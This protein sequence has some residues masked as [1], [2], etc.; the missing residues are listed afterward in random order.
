M[1]RRARHGATR[2]AFV[3]IDK[4]SRGLAISGK[5]GADDRHRNPEHWRCAADPLNPARLAADAPDMTTAT[6]AL[7]TRPGEPIPGVA[8]RPHHSRTIALLRRL[9]ALF[10]RTP[11]TP[12]PNRLPRDA[13]ALEREVEF[14]PPASRA[15]FYIRLGHLA[16]R[17]EERS[18]ALRYYGRAIDAYLETGYHGAAA[19]LCRKVIAMAPEVVRARGTLAF[20][21]VGF[22][23]PAEAERAIAE[24][25]CAARRAG[26]EATL[27]VRLRAMATA[28]ADPEIRLTLGR[29]LNELG[30]HTGANPVFGAVFAEQRGIRRAPRE[31][32]AE[33]WADLLRTVIADPYEP[34]SEHA[35]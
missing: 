26:T 24:Y 29:H 18:R 28:T 10:R 6:G 35:A 2:S 11:E 4:P 32:A 12:K 7:R 9:I 33:R 31:R 27:T 5:Y 19:A 15:H 23:S 8:G 13:E 25:V 14:A 3:R 17:A 21:T 30:D 16:M 22:G 1:R 20:L 34:E